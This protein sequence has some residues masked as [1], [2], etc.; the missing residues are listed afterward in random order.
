MAFGQ[1]LARLREEAGLTQMQLAQQAGVSVDTL[2]HW[3][4]GRHLPR[5]DDAYR[6]ARALGVGVEKLILGTDLEEEAEQPRSGPTPG[7]KKRPRGR[8]RKGE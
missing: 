5:V 7:P 6:L 1:T 8:K 4:Q 2:R 3:E